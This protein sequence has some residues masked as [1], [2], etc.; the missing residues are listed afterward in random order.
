MAKKLPEQIQKQID[1]VNAFYQQRED[2]AKAESETESAVTDDA[3]QEATPAVQPVDAAAAPEQAPV[4][5]P[6]Q[7]E[8]KP[9]P[10]KDDAAVWEQRYKTLQGMHNQNIADLKQRLEA[11]QAENKGLAERLSQIEAAA[12][13][14]KQTVDP[15]F[16]EEFGEDLVGMVQAIVKSNLE[17]AG[18]QFDSQIKNLDGKVHNTE[19]QLAQ[20]AEALFLERLAKEVPDLE[21]MNVD[22]GFLAWL[23]EEDPVY[24]LPRQTALD[25]AARDHDV[26]R[27]ARIFQ[28]YARMQKAPEPPAQPAKPQRAAN[29]QLEKQVAPRAGVSTPRAA[30]GSSQ[31]I[32]SSAEVTQFYDDVRRGV[33]RGKEDEMNAREL[34]INRALAE[35]RI[36]A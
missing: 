18:T 13:Q 31:R 34:E 11:A 12:Q 26:G 16:V 9:E 35:G 15:K 28:E 19:Q 32:I 21:R 20:T 30:D 8:P 10:V 3:T 36:T 22:P 2:A 25:R 1:E 23:A 29:P 6:A 24:G 5:T 17:H 27:T 33:F 14:A 7:P 4:E